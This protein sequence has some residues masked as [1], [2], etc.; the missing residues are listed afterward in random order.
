MPILCAVDC[1]YSLYFVQ[2]PLE[3]PVYPDSNNKVQVEN[4]SG[5]EISD[6][7]KFNRTELFKDNVISKPENPVV[8]R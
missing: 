5:T 2:A 7:G 1:T 4:S 6:G 8:R 3:C